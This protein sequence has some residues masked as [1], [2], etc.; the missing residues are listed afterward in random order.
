LN[1]NSTTQIL[2]IPT[3]SGK[4]AW[5]DYVIWDI[6]GNTRSGTIISVW[7]STDVNWT[8]ISN[9]GLPSPGGFTNCVSFNMTNISGSVSLKGM[10]NGC[11]GNYEVL[12]TTRVTF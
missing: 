6:N 10:L 7:T 2:T 11:G 1:D 9:T 3:S 12:V 5:F 8:D 4:A